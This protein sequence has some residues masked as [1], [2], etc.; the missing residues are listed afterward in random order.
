MSTTITVPPAV[1]DLFHSLENFVRKSGAWTILVNDFTHT[2]GVTNTANLNSV[3][4]ALAG[5]ILYADHKAA[6]TPSV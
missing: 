1:M 5:V 3:L 2:F 4:T 6:K